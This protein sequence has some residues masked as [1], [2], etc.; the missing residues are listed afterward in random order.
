[1]AALTIFFLLTVA[2]L[3]SVGNA[4]TR[5]FAV[6]GYV[7]EWR[8]DGLDWDTLSHH[9]THLILFSLEVVEDGSLTAMD[10]LP[11][12]ESFIE[13]RKTTLA[14]STKLLICFG[15]YGRSGGFPVLVQDP[16]ARAK[17]LQNLL[18]FIEKHNLDGVD[19][20]WEYPRGSDEWTGL[21]LL[22]AE[23]RALLGPMKVITM[24]YYPDG[25]QEHAIK[26]TG[27]VEHVDLILMMCYDQPGRHAT[28]E[29]MKVASMRSLTQL[30]SRK[31]ALGL[32]FYSRHTRTGDWKSYDELLRLYGDE[33]ETRSNEVEGHF[34]NGPFLIARKTNYALDNDFGG[35]MIWEVGQDC[36]SYSTSSCSDR[37]VNRTFESKDRSL[38]STVTQYINR[39]LGQVSRSFKDEL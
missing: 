14:H 30:P 34:F 27:M 38:H 5:P 19:Y 32:P 28:E 7:P 16:A 4:A 26:M 8:Y 18:A 31:L 39:K 11:K 35:V 21:A 22:I 33:M 13:A 9:N 3:A 29:F 23:T 17:F 15:G 10:R 37:N 25:A 36:N 6:V 2:F 1:M 24:A 20:N 12:P